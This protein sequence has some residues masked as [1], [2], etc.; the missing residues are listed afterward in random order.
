[1]LQRRRSF[2][3]EEV[4]VTAT[5]REARLIDTRKRLR[6]VS[7]DIEIQCAVIS[8]LASSYPISTKPAESVPDRAR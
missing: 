5:K 2:A 4:V 8:G 7:E 3:L 1:V 6:A